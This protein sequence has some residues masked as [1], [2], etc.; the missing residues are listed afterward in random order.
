MRCCVVQE[1][2]CARHKRVLMVMVV[3][4]VVC[5]WCTLM[6]MVVVVA[7]IGF[8]TQIC[9]NYGAAYALASRSIHSVSAAALRDVDRVDAARQCV[10]NVRSPRVCYTCCIDTFL[11]IPI[12]NKCLTCVHMLTRKNNKQMCTTFPML[13]VRS[14]SQT[15]G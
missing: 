12:S 2:A 3:M 8:G 7:V 1:S 5:Y 10:L 4:L 9:A 15:I 14:L 13:F 11:F 6:M